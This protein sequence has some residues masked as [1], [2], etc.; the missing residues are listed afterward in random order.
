MQFRLRTLLILL[1]IGPPMLAWGL[2]NGPEVLLVPLCILVIFLPLVVAVTFTVY[3]VRNRRFSLGSLFWFVTFE[4]VSIAA[5]LA[6]I[7]MLPDVQ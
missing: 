1:A 7:R 6:I 4:A 2:L 5:S 3:A